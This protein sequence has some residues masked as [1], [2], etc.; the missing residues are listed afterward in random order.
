MSCGDREAVCKAAVAALPCLGTDP[1]PSQELVE[2]HVRAIR[3]LQAACRPLPPD[4]DRE[5]PTTRNG[6]G[7]RAPFPVKPAIY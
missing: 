3:D 6:G 1:N 7:A 5:T 2:E 4:S